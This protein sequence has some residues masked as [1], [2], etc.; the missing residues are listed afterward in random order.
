[1]G[2]NVTVLAGDGIGPEIMAVTQTVLT[3]V[4]AQSE[5]QIQFNAQL[6]GGAAIDVTG[7]PFPPATQAAV[8]TADAVLLG[9]VGGP[10]WDE[11]TERPEQGLLALRKQMGVFA[12]VRPVK[13]F[14]A[15]K[16]LS[17][18]REERLEA[19]DFV[20]VRELLGGLYFGEPKYFNEKEGV[21]TLRYDKA[22][23]ERIV[24]YAFK[25][26]ATRKGE[27]T[28]I[29]KANVLASSKLWRQTVEEIAPLYREV[30]V[31]H[32]YVDAAAMHLIQRPA[33][34]DVI[35]TE[36]MFGDI[37]SDEAS[38]LGGSL[39]LLPS[40]SH[41]QAGRAALYE[42]IHGSAP[43]I[44]GQDCANPIGMLLSAAMMLRQSFQ[45]EAEA[46]QIETA[47]ETA[48]AAGFLTKD[49]GGQTS[50]RAFGAKIS[51]LI[52]RSGAN[53]TTNIV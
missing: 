43:D 44:A 15:V 7:S 8:A 48:L 52:E 9:S 29:D 41:A 42:P 36:N 35:V 6:F 17:P 46:T 51:E 32:L 40:S 38:V 14:S 31:T 33:Q 24:H 10:K 22:S 53:V 23:I 49:L 19:V 25:L 12:N 47:V 26:A 45:L 50:T 21:D 34:F 28:S 30:R 27:L 13:I 18:L 4:L 20:V 5:Q 1:M 37:L 16:H 3:Q 39:G 2:Y 11:A